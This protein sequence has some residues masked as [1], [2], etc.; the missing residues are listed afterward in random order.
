MTKT[1]IKGLPEGKYWTE[2]GYSQSY[3]WIEIAR[4][5]KTVTLAKVKTK[6][7]PEW[8]AKREFIP[9]GFCGHVPNQSEQTWLFDGI[10][11]ENV[12]KI[13]KTK[14]GWSHKG[15]VFREDRAIEFYDY[16]F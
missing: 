8:L 15:V 7:D 6:N 3:P 16:N 4:T 10:N 9:G 1:N 14:R 11:V 12:K 2:Y 5:E 13:R